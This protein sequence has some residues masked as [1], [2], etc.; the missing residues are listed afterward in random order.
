MRSKTGLHAN[1]VDSRYGSCPG[2]ENDHLNRRMEGGVCEA[3]SGIL[4]VPGGLCQSM[5]SS[6]LS[7]AGQK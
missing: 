6:V 4:H 2:N 3:V 5:T 7:G 1:M